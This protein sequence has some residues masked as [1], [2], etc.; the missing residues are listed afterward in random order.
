MLLKLD[1][2]HLLYYTST[3]K[4]STWPHLRPPHTEAA[5]RTTFVLREGHASNGQN[6]HFATTGTILRESPRKHEQNSHFATRL[7]TRPAGSCERV[8]WARV[9]FAFRYTVHV[10]A[11]DRPDPARRSPEHGSNLHFATR[12]ALDRPDPVRGSA[13]GPSRFATGLGTRQAGSPATG[14]L[15]ACSRSEMS[16]Q[17]VVKSLASAKTWRSLSQMLKLGQVSRKC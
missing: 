5:S 8:A 12:F 1:Q 10:W 6:S 16:R 11:L 17:N 3:P 4:S 13:R 14:S 2:V 9:K 15:L 7:G